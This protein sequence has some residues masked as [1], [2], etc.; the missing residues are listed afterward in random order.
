M[1]TNE[2]LLKKH[3][4]SGYEISRPVLTECWFGLRHS[5]IIIQFLYALMYYRS[6]WTN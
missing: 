5:K 4:L 2:D 1:A 3:A 6:L